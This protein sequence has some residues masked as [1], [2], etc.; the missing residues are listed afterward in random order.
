M[1]QQQQQQQQN[2]FARSTVDQ[3]ARECLF[4]EFEAYRAKHAKELL[5][6]C[7]EYG[8]GSAAWPLPNW[9]PV[10]GSDVSPENVR[11]G[12]RCMSKV[13]WNDATTVPH[14]QE[15]CPSPES[16]S[17][18][19]RILNRREEMLQRDL[20]KQQ[21]QM[22]MQMQNANAAS[23]IKG[24]TATKTKTNTQT[25]TKT[26]TRASASSKSKAMSK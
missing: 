22:Q 8:V 13:M 2:R 18:I 11:E 12:K 17:M 7:Q 26:K 3:Q 19:E 20:R 6:A 10:E 24:K 1:K 15:K 25:K 16:R 5:K 9:N 21:Q 23:S 14:L 4:G